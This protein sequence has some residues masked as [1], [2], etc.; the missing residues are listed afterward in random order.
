MLILIAA[1]AAMPCRALLLRRADTDAAA[2]YA[3]AE[4]F[5]PPIDFR[6]RRRYAFFC[7]D[8]SREI[9]TK[10]I[11]TP[12]LRHAIIAAARPAVFI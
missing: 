2:D 5:Q 8:Y 4:P 3:F 1:F 12:P 10:M 6:Q 11:A 7:I 9:A